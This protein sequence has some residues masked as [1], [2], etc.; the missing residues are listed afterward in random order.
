MIQHTSGVL[1]LIWPKRQHHAGRGQGKL[2]VK[3]ANTGPSQNL[4]TKQTRIV[5]SCKLLHNRH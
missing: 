2:Q 4:S 5:A 1:M 3:A